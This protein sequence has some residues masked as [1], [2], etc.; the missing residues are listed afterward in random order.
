MWLALAAGLASGGP[1]QAQQPSP[2]LAAPAV[3]AR[4]VAL[5]PGNRPLGEL[6][7]ELSRQ[8]R[9]PF[10]YSSSLIPVGHCYRLAAGPPR[11]LGVV[12]REVLA[13]THLSYGLLDGQLVLWPAHA[14]LPAGVTAVNGSP[15]NSGPPLPDRTAFLAKGPD[16]AYPASSAA[17]SQS[18]Q[19]AGAPVRNAGLPGELRRLA[20]GAGSVR[21][22]LAA[23]PGGLAT[24]IGAPS[25]HKTPG[26]PAEAVGQAA[27]TRSSPGRARPHSVVRTPPSSEDG[28]LNSGAAA[29]ASAGAPGTADAARA[30]PPAIAAT[31]PAQ[32]PGAPGLPMRRAAG[33]LPASGSPGAGTLADRGTRRM[34]PAA[35]DLLEPLPARPVFAAL[36]SAQA[37]VPRA[38]ALASPY[39][40]RSALGRKVAAVASPA[41]LLAGL[42]GRAYLHGEAWASATLPLSAT[43]KVG[44]RPIYLILGA[45]LAPAGRHNGAAWGLGLG[46]AGQ[47]RGRFTPS[48]DVLLWLLNGD[49]DDV[50]RTQLTQL[51][52]QL[53][54]QL[55]QGGRLQL[56]GGPTLN[57]ATARRTMG[58]RPH[59]AVGQDQWLWFES[60]DDQP[61][62]RLWPGI[63][64]GLRF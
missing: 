32:S 7:A 17:E 63:Q 60:L 14:A 25:R 18:T 24:V 47:A 13:A 46:T 4:P 52:P 31:S 59:W 48:L 11:P 53:A 49:G 58:T 37:G 28:N 45:A 44:V 5:K 36:D 39:P 15:A 33:A 3:L 34:E 38:G 43:V 22:T 2:A 54:W 56:V 62:V 8:S 64:L 19:K 21:P 27:S 40:T 9:L 26:R 20:P 57:L 23:E 10:S 41:P 29:A 55:K 50:G 12:L 42:R 1:A 16:P 51:R 6:L 61:L 35:P 30:R